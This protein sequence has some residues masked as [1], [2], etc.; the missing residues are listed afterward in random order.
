MNWK[1]I[2]T[3]PPPKGVDILAYTD[4]GCQR[5]VRWTGKAFNTYLK[6]LFWQ[7]LPEGPEVEQDIEETVE[8]KKR[9]RK[10]KG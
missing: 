10:K 5:V 2:N 7:D 6:V 9:G 4:D 8:P 1:N 3:D